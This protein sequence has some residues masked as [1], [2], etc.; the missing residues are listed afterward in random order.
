MNFEH[1]IDNLPLTIFWTGT[2]TW[3]CQKDAPVSQITNISRSSLNDKL[4]EI[5]QFKNLIYIW[6]SDVIDGV[7]E[8]LRVVCKTKHPHTFSC[9]I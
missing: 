3:V 8:A 2:E 9:K 5:W 6:R 4:T 7:I 1:G